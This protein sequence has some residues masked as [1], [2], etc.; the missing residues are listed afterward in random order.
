MLTIVS[1]P[2]KDLSWEYYS[3]PKIYSYTSCAIFAARHAM[4]CIFI[5]GH[6][7]IPNEEENV[8]MKV[9]ISQWKKGERI[10]ICRPLAVPAY[11]PLRWFSHIS[12]CRTTHPKF[13]TAITLG[14]LRHFSNCTN[15]IPYPHSSLPFSMKPFLTTSAQW[16]L[17][18][19]SGSYSVGSY[20]SFHVLVLYHQWKYDHLKRQK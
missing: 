15:P 11:L 14:L 9:G 10:V 16:P 13:I 19:L 12:S 8:P 2:F 17:H 1:G 7:S 6:I 5:N 3:P 20:L 18:L 4:K